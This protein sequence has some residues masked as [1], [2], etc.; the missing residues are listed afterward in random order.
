[1][2]CRQCGKELPITFGGRRVFCSEECLNAYYGRKPK[3]KEKKQCEHCGIDLPKGRTKY[4]SKK[5]SDAAFSKMNRKNKICEVCGKELVE[6]QKF[7]CSPECAKE[8]RR[9]NKN[10]QCRKPK[11]EPKKKGRPK[12]VVSVVEICKR[13]K[14]EGLTYGQYVGKY[15]M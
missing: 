14:E 1:M 11:S 6:R 10:E 4:C 5:C 2:N 12:K 13:A 3:K 8:A 7:Y 15:G 9:S